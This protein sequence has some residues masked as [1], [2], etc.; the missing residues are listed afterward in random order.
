MF[1]VRSHS[2][3]GYSSNIGTLTFLL[4]ICGRIFN[5]YVS[6]GGPIHAHVPIHAHRK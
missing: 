2:G 3:R 4:Q 1:Y 5:A 6:G